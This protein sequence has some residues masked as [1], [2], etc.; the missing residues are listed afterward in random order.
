MKDEMPDML[1]IESVNSSPLGFR[2]T[3]NDTGSH[4]ANIS[5][6]MILLTMLLVRGNR[7][8]NHLVS[9]IFAIVVNMLF[10]IVIQEVRR[11]SSVTISGLDLSS[12]IILNHMTKVSLNILILGWYDGP[13]LKQRTEYW[14]RPALGA[15]TAL[16]ALV[17]RLAVL[18]GERPPAW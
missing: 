17:E 15:I 5:I 14:H 6:M 13:R 18:A 4:L 9:G 11:C 12:N 1:V 16:A 7:A 8:V 3:L 2:Q 10:R